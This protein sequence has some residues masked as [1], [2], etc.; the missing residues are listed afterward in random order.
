MHLIKTVIFLPMRSFSNC[1]LGR[2]VY[3]IMTSNALQYFRSF[4]T[5]ILIFHFI[6]LSE[7]YLKLWTSLYY[8]NAWKIYENLLT[9]RKFWNIPLISADTTL[10]RKEK[11][12]SAVWSSD[13]LM[14]R[15]CKTNCS[16][17]TRSIICNISM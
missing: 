13:K 4:L 11:T 6:D 15:S 2:R 12:S 17:T 1:R 14:R 5:R 9:K 8:L 7:V 10:S 3:I 16:S